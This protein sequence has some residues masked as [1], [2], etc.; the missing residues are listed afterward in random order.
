M[1]NNE[2]VWIGTQSEFDELTE[3][4]EN[5]LQEVYS[6]VIRFNKYFETIRGN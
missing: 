6:Y 3:N 4:D 5:E 2:L 1:N